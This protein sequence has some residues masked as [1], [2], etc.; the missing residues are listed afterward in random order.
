MEFKLAFRKKG[1]TKVLGTTRFV[2]KVSRSIELIL[3]L[4]DFGHLLNEVTWIVQSPNNG[5][6]INRNRRF[7]KLVFI[8]FASTRTSTKI[9]ASLLINEASFNKA[10][11]NVSFLERL[12]CFFYAPPKAAVDLEIQALEMQIRFAQATGARNDFVDH[13][14]FL[15]EITKQKKWSAGVVQWMEQNC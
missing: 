3:E 8:D 14:I 7:G 2:E 6:Q 9:L 12:R 1:K 5:N 10:N 11:Q 4:P 15:V 13:L